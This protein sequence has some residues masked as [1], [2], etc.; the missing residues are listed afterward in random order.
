[1]VFSA[2]LPG[3][4]N[5]R[6]YSFNADMAICSWVGRMPASHRVISG[7]QFVCS[8][9]RIVCRQDDRNWSSLL[10]SLEEMFIASMP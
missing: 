7:G 4:D 8:P 6:L 3:L 2:M 9:T 5:S 10:V 1:M